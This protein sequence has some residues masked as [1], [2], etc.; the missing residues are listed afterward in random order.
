MV[1]DVQCRQYSVARPIRTERVAAENRAVVRDI[2][3]KNAT[4]GAPVRR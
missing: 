2:Q 1:F 3:R 4:S